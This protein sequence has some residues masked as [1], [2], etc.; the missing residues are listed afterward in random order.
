MIIL[1]FIVLIFLII[2]FIFA[3]PKLSPIPYYPSNKKDKTLIIQA[4]DIKNNEVIIDL[5]AGDGWVIFEAA[6]QSLARGYSTRFVAV[7][8]N[9]IL[10]LLMNIK[11]L[12]HPNKKNITIMRADF[13]S[14]EFWKKLISV[15]NSSFTIHNYV[16]YLY[17]SPRLMDKT[18]TLI[19]KNFPN[20]STVTYLY[21]FKNI[22]PTKTLQGVK[23]IYIYQ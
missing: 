5:G 4:L 7:D 20:A 9:P 1:V 15:H 2:L 16:F 13:F 8:I 21:P 6:R 3:S 10:F 12:F 22:K 11:R 17:I 23:K 14:L 18:R 19:L